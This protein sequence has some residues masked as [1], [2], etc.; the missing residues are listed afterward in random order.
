MS[1]NGLDHWLRLL[2]FPHLVLNSANKSSDKGKNYIRSNLEDFKKIVDVKSALE[3]L[4]LKYGG[5]QYKKSKISE[6]LVIKTANR[7]VGE[8]LASNETVAEATPETKAKLQSK[9]PHDDEVNVVF[10]K[11]H[12]LK[13]TQVNDVLEAIR[14]FPISSS[15]DG[16]RPRHLKDLTSFTCGESASNLL[17]SIASLSDLAKTGKICEDILPIFYGAS[18]IAFVKKKVDV[19]PI[20]VCYGHYLQKRSQHAFSEIAFIRSG[21]NLPRNVSNDPSSL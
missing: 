11:E 12:D 17:K 21:R 10:P 16:L 19:R 2:A 5:T 4:L 20:A 9:H 1:K 7:K 18:L 15:S 6:D 13:V 14:N 8:V 3:Q